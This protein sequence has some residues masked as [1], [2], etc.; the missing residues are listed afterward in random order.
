MKE[1]PFFQAGFL[2]FFLKKL[3][4]NTTRSLY[5]KYCPTEMNTIP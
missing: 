4:D 3:I 5:T 1:P 2:F